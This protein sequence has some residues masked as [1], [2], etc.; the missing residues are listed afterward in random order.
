MKQVTQV[1][2]MSYVCG[3]AYTKGGKRA[4]LIRMRPSKF[5]RQLAAA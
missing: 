5:P 2:Q 4:K 3:G 1:K